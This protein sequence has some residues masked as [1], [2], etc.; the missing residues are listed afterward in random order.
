MGDLSLC[1][2][3]EKEGDVP[4]A[5]VFVRSL[6]ALHVEDLVLKRRSACYRR[7]WRP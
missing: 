5:S 4:V 6:L 3:L 1:C 7:P 2:K